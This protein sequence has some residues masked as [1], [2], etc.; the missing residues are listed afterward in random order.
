MSMKLGF[1]KTISFKYGMCLDHTKEQG[2]FPGFQRLKRP[3][4]WDLL[5]GDDWLRRKIQ[6]EASGC[7]LRDTIQS[8]FGR[9]RVGEADIS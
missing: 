2:Q 1:I 7:T 3:G 9:R 6:K 4:L 8:R 5:L